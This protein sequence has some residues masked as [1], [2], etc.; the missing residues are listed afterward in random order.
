MICPHNARQ[1]ASRFATPP[2]IPLLFCPRIVLN[3]LLEHFTVNVVQ[4]ENRAFYEVNYKPF[5]FF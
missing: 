3:D 5:L 4:I 2:S 1:G